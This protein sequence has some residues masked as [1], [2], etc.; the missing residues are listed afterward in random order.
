MSVSLDPVRVSHSYTTDADVPSILYQVSYCHWMYFISAS[1][2]QWPSPCL[3]QTLHHSEVIKRLDSCAA[4]SVTGS[5]Y[6]TFHSLLQIV[7]FKLGNKKRA[8]S[9]GINDLCDCYT[10]PVLKNEV[11]W[12]SRGVEIFIT[13][14]HSEGWQ[15]L[16][17][18]SNDPRRV[19]RMLQFTN[20][21]Q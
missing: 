9:L 14:W 1:C 10:S 13:Y 15:S 6:I 4:L 20:F 7:F 2:L 11:F 12:I 21:P 19:T 3:F 5:T 8:I 17:L 18:L 16:C